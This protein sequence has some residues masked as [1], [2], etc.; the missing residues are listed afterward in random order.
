MLDVGRVACG[1]IHL[2]QGPAE[3]NIIG[4]YVEWRRQIRCGG[5]QD[6]LNTPAENSAVRAGHADIADERGAIRQDLLIGGRNMRM[7]A[8]DGADPA[9]KIMA[10]EIF[11]G[12]GLGVHIDDHDP[13]LA[14]ELGSST[15]STAWNGQSTGRMKVR[16]SKL[17][18]AT[19]VPSGAAR[20]GEFA[21]RRRR[22][23]NSLA[24][25]CAHPL[26]HADDFCFLVDVVARA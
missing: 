16:P 23:E 17:T 18:T 13:S 8:E 6:R 24:C 7:R 19:V 3:A 15:R 2:D 1:R 12:R 4:G 5:S 25:K 14:I 9:I 11:V 22:P 26:Q 10:H 20:D 21:A